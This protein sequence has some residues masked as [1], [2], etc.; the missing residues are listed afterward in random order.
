MITENAIDAF[1]KMLEKLYEQNAQS[2]SLQKAKEKAWQRFLEIGL[3]TRKS[4]AFQYIRTSSLYNRSFEFSFSPNIDSHILTPFIL[5]ECAASVV[6]LVN[7]QYRPDLSRLSA[8]P[9]RL[10]I[11]PLHE[12]YRTYGNY[13]N[14]QWSKLLKEETDPFSLLNAALY[15]QGMFLYAPPKTILDTPIQIL[16]VIAAEDIPLLMLPRV[17]GYIGSQSQLD[18]ISTHTYLTY[19]ESLVSLSIDLAIDEDS[20][21]RFIQ[22]PFNQLKQ[23]WYFDALRTSL[24]RNSTF[25]TVLATE[26]SSSQ[27]YD[28]R[29]SLLG[30][31]AEANLNGIWMLSNNNEAHAHVLIDHQAPHCRS[32]QLF[33]GVLND[34]SHSSFEGKILVQ[35]Q[36]QKTEA[37]Q[38]NNNLLLSDKARAESKPNL[39]IFADDVKASHG[40]T[41][42]QLD[43]EQLF[44]LK[45]RGYSEKAAQN[46]LVYGYCK[47]VFDLIPN[48]SIM[49][50]IHNHAK[51]YLTKDI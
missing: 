5:P 22:R 46:L 51:R 17:H 35:Q 39:E 1:Q 44:Y 40:A 16:Q 14:N 20:H 50:D 8:L 21:V 47:E 11:L 30:E 10:I 31:N 19:K 15:Q 18:L 9:K 49:N 38:L 48:P 33:K 23:S 25:K 26:G 2:D 13:L 37:F 34:A 45:T 28:Y 24:K 4:E 42:G 36:A 32:M 41:V 3:P 27:R 7:G 29:V 6:V 12:A 43:K